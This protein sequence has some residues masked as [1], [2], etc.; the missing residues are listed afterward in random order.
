MSVGASIRLLSGVATRLFGF[1][2]RTIPGVSLFER[3]PP[4]PRIV[5]DPTRLPPG[6]VL[7]QKWPVL[8]HGSVP[9]YDLGKWRLSIGG[10]VERPEV[11]WHSEFVALP[12][13]DITID[14]HCVT[15]WSRLDNR[16]TG[17][18]MPW[19]MER[20]GV[21]DSVAFVVFRCA[22]GF[23]TSIPRAVAESPECALVWKHDGENLAPEHGWPLRALVPRKY[24]W[25]SAK[26][27]EAVE[28]VTEDQ[29][30]FWERNG[31]NNSADPWLEER[32]W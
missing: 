25:K 5:A 17:V 3:K 10:E 11:F 9:T 1:G 24:F 8:H 18:S 6:Q 20:V 7:T 30:G 27:L 12:T 14:I 22:S 15:T 26:W 29:L 32:Y 23:T 4:D 31:Y 16:F 21:R 13:V 2:G 19:L 28:F